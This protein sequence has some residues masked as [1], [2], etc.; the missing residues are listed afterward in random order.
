MADCTF[1][2]DCTNEVTNADAPGFNTPAASICCG[3]I[4]KEP[5]AAF[6]DP[7]ASLTIPV[8]EL[9]TDAALAAAPAATPLTID[10]V[11]PLSNAALVAGVL[12][13]AVDA[14]AGVTGFGGVDAVVLFVDAT[15]VLG[16]VGNAA[17]ALVVI[18]TS[19][20]WLAAAHGACAGALLTIDVNNPGAAAKPLVASPNVSVCAT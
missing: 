11:T 4:A 1:E 14:T 8:P 3:V 20:P 12:L 9:T 18:L 7:F 10:A 5:T 2:P 16:A 13:G 19:T 17:L 6:K 15:A